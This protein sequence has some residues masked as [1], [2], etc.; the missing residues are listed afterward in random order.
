MEG[1]SVRRT[2][3]VGEGEAGDVPG[4]G[5]RNNRLGENG[6]QHLQARS[7][8]AGTG[9]R[10]HL[11]IQTRRRMLVL[12]GMEREPVRCVPVRVLVPVVQQ[13]VGMDGRRHRVGRDPRN[14]EQDDEEGRRA[15][16]HGAEV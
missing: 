11:A 6:G 8:L 14:Q 2:G 10:G 15:E 13:L 5:R 16:T 9:R 1:R 4:C 7:G 3:S 12:S